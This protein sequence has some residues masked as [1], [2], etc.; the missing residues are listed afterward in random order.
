VHI[1]AEDS[2]IV[3]GVGHGGQKAGREVLLENAEQEGI[4]EE[5]LAGGGEE[6]VHVAADRYVGNLTERGVTVQLGHRA[7]KVK[8]QHPIHLAWEMRLRNA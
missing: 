8:F 6:T 5:G 3:V 7:L 2:P 4:R 1:R